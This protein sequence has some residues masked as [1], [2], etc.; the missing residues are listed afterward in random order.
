MLLLSILI[1]PGYL[2]YMLLRTQE[3]STFRW[4]LRVSFT[5]LFLI[6]LF[7]AGRW[8]WVSYYLRFIWL[9]L[10][11]A[12]AFISYTRLG[13]KPFFVAKSRQRWLRIANYAFSL[14]VT[15]VLLGLTTRGYVYT[16]EPVRLAMP[17]K[18]G[19]H[20][21]AQGGNSLT[22][23]YHKSNRSQQFAMDIVQLNSVGARANGIYPSNLQ[24]YVVFGQP[25]YSPCD[26]TV[27]ATVDHLPDLTPPERDTENLAG[28]HVALT[29]RDVKLL[30]AHLQHD[31]VTVEPGATV[32]TGQL[33]G[34]VG[35]SGNTTEP[36]LHLHAVES[37]SS[38]FEGDAVPILFEEGFLTRNA[39]F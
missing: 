22:L 10:F 32:E 15:L 7:L 24:R 37:G 14:L 31:S 11:A 5:G 29:C 13:D 3:K 27:T 25:V 16:D 33:L 19:R 39:I 9:T 1:L 6:Y 36:H 38:V 30:L 35:N 34:R 8:D 20:Y 21:V 2:L 12:A 4:L 17:L 28:N 26:G 18:E 23:N